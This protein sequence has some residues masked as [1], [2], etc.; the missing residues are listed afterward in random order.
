[1]RLIL[2]LIW[3][4]AQR[5]PG[6]YLTSIILISLV[7]L[8]W[9]IDPLYTRYAIDTMLLAKEGQPV[10]FYRIFAIWGLIFIAHALLQSLNKFTTWKLDNM[11]VLERR[12]E[13]F[14]HVLNLGI[15]FH[16]KQKSGEVVKILDEGADTLMDLQRS[17]LIDLI[18]SFMTAV[19]FLIFGFLI[20]PLMAGILLIGLALYLGIAFIG[21]Q[22]TMKLQHEVNALWVTSIGRAFDAILNIY[23][24][25]SGSQE[26]REIQRMQEIHKETFKRQ[27]AVNR[28]WAMVE[29]VNFFFLT[30]ILLVS[31]GIYLFTQDLIS[32]GEVY[33]FQSSFYRVLTPFEIL[34]GLLPQWNR[35]VGK[36]RLA[37]QIRQTLVDIHNKPTVRDISDLKGAISL[38][39]L[40]FSYEEDRGV[41]GDGKERSDDIKQV[42]QQ[43]EVPEA[44]E[45][46]AHPIPTSADNDS[47]EEQEKQFFPTPDAEDRH[48]GEVLH[49]VMLTIK[50]GEHI[51]FVGH[52]GAGK[53]TLAMLLNRFYDPT[54]GRITV[55]G[56]DLRDLDVHWWRSQI[57]LVLQ[58]NLLFNETV[59]ENIRYAR[60]AAT[61]EEVQEAARRAAAYDFIERLPK[62]YDTLVGDRGV[63]LSGGER[64]RIAIA[65][66][67]LKQ[68]KV[69]IL[70]EA[71]SALDSITERAVQEGIKELITGRTACIIAHRLSTVR[72]VNRTAVLDKGKLIACAPHE[73]LMKT[74]AVYREMVE[75]QSHG[76]LAE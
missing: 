55:D 14:R 40:C 67:I 24:V 68:P 21:T 5:H 15:S 38:E 4:Q 64:Q 73:E 75:L 52:S 71:T 10:N 59:L 62:K 31:I 34:G 46:R 70:D 54:S 72:S 32:L 61:Q 28:R 18:P 43:T 30:R 56:I 57:G 16:T 27:Q 45:E 65:R 48:P 7:A 53:S 3:Q 23:S 58:E 35:Q 63:K 69:V 36:V 50:P 19:A 74:C 51:A 33:F 41:I 29:G 66:A 1:M 20:S 12:E 37:E 47:L 44:E 39:S 76:M 17:L 49:N 11:M 60:P 22:S 13:V 25:K 8:V 2:R 6:T 9:V 26:Q 42:H